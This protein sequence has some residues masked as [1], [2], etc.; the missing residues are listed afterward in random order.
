MAKGNNYQIYSQIDYCIRQ[1]YS[2]YMASTIV[3]EKRTIEKNQNKEFTQALDKETKSNI[4]AQARSDMHGINS[5]YRAKA[6]ADATGK[7]SKMSVDDLVDR[8]EHKW[9]K[10]KRLQNDYNTFVTA[11]YINLVA[12]NGGKESRKL[13]DYANSYVH[14]RFQTLIIEQLAREKVPR[15]TASYIAKKAFS[16]SLISFAMPKF[17]LKDGEFGDKVDSKAEGIYNPSIA[18]KAA[19]YVGAVLLDMVATAGFGGAGTGAKTATKGAQAA[20]KKGMK[21]IS[22]S[23]DFGIRAFA[24]HKSANKWSNEEYA[25]N[26]SK[27]VFGDENAFKKI[28]D[29]SAQYRKGS[30]EFINNINSALSRKIKV[31]PLSTTEQAR[32]ESNALLVQHKGNSAKLLNTIK[33]DFS[34]QCV[35]FNGN[36]KIPDWMLNNSSK[37]NR[38]LAASFYACAMEMSRNQQHERKFGGKKMTINEVAQRAY[39]YARAADAIDKHQAQIHKRAGFSAETQKALDDFD[40][41]MAKLN[42]DIDGTSTQKQRASTS[43]GSSSTTRQAT[44]PSTTP[45]Y[46]QGNNPYVQQQEQPQQSTGTAIPQ[47]TA[48]WGNALEQLGLNG[49]SDVSK[50]MGYVLAMLPDMLIGMFTGKNPNMKLDDNLLPLAAIIGGLFVKNPLLKMLLIGF[51]GANLFNKAGHAALSQGYSKT[52]KAVTYKTYSDEPLNKRISSPVMKG[53]SMV[54][55]ID[56]KPVVINI[57]DD[58]VD[59]YE[60]GN[61]PLNTLANAVLRKYDESNALASRN[62]ELQHQDETIEQQRGL[63]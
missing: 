44:T 2:K 56:G 32:K 46:M 16:D 26:D 11:F 53:S 4:W 55:T 12:Q 42:A 17:G 50:N 63:K 13:W 40:A 59:A 6:L 51:G 19:G 7:W 10:D 33:A 8:C 31:A 38:A 39:D 20:A 62:Y 49:F 5:V 35:S 30:T 1:Y 28:Q 29:G 52:P 21:L 61:V 54:A 34:K 15:N 22:P 37:Q 41:N 45:A 60:R 27:A 58:A 47:Q 43:R 9:A 23:I 25:K 36:S 14:N 57:S 18:S 48:G 24:G 3:Q